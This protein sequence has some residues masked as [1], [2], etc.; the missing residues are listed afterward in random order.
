MHAC[1]DRRIE[2]WAPSLLLTFGVGVLQLY[3]GN[4]PSS[5]KHGANILEMWEEE[6]EKGNIYCLLTFHH[7]KSNPAFQLFVSKKSGSIFVFTVGTTSC[8]KV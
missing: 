8:I 6:K 7:E 2:P 1:Q 5:V 3:T 4:Y